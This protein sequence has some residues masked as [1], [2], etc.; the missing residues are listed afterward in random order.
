MVTNETFNGGLTLGSLGLLLYFCS[1]NPN[2]STNRPI[3]PDTV[4]SEEISS[5]RL[6]EETLDSMVKRDFENTSGKPIASF[7]EKLP[8]RMQ[9]WYDEYTKNG[10]MLKRMGKT[11]ERYGELLESASNRYNIPYDLLLG[12]VLVESGGDTKKTSRRGAKGLLQIMPETGKF[13]AG[14]SDLKCT[15][16]YQPD[17]NIPCGAFYLSWIYQN[18]TESFPNL[19]NQERWDLTLAAYNRGHNG[20]KRDLKKAEVE[21]FLELKAGDINPE[22]YDYVSKVRTI[23]RMEQEKRKTEKMRINSETTEA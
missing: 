9:K 22:T 12:A 8:P 14:L 7:E 21:S 11:E 5:P 3:R 20:I 4:I 15:D 16:L 1:V 19:S 6:S 13:I 17:V 2:S 18:M 23:E 10:L